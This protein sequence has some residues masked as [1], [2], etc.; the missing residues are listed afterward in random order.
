M[1]ADFR[2]KKL[3][4]W[5]LLLYLSMT[6][7]FDCKIFEKNKTKSEIDTEASKF[8]IDFGHIQTISDT[9]IV[10]NQ[11]QRVYKEGTLREIGKVKKNGQKH[12]VWYKYSNDLK[13]TA[14]IYFRSDSISSP[15]LL[16]NST[17]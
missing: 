3:F 11:L 2:L 10:I 15:I 13:L 17:W 8:K 16:I 5:K 6:L 9:I 1:Q 4:L 7:L 14:V 12:G